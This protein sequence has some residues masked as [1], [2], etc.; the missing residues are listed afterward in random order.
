MGKRKSRK[1]NKIINT[2]L[3]K[4]I[5]ERGRMDIRKQL[6]LFILFIY[7]RPIPFF[8]FSGP[9]IVIYLR[10]KDQQDA[11]FFP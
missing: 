8:T 3:A 1:K 4:S 2:L 5:S 6:R 7:S 11:L 9:C 10:N